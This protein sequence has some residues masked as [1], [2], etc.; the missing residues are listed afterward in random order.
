MSATFRGFTTIWYHHTS[1]TIRIMDEFTYYGSLLATIANSR[2]LFNTKRQ[3]GDYIGFSLE[4]NSITKIRSSFQRKAIFAELAQEFG[5]LGTYEYTLVQLIE[6]YELASTFYV[7]V[8]ERYF[9]TDRDQ[10]LMLLLHYRFG[11]AELPQEQPLREVMASIYNK[12]KDDERVSVVF[13]LLLSLHVLPKF[14]ARG[15][16][17]D[18]LMDDIDTVFDFLRRFVNECGVMPNLPLV[19]INHDIL[20]EAKA[21]DGA[22]LS[23]YC[24]AIL[25]NMTHEILNRNRYCCHPILTQQYINELDATA[26]PLYLDGLWVENE[27]NDTVFWKLQKTGRNSTFATRYMFSHDT[28]SGN[29]VRYYM[30]FYTDNNGCTIS[31]PQLS[32][33]IIK[34]GIPDF[35]WV[36]WYD[37]FV[38]DEEDTQ[39]MEFERLTANPNLPAKLSLHRV[40]SDKTLELYQKILDTYDIKDLYPECHYDFALSS[41]AITRNAIYIEADNGYFRIPFDSNPNFE[42]ASLDDK[43]GMLTMGN[44]TYIAFDERGIYLDV[45]DVDEAKEKYNITLHD[46]I[47][48]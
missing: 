17:I 25:I 41:S 1:T 13:L 42:G 47:S 27:G 39:H 35:T 19:Q 24:R 34:Q 22:Q 48:L 5:N 21:N 18:N 40:N 29:Y 12:E 44:R 4:V 3:L 26:N 2:L 14:T 31:M 10:R 28:Q 36:A 20:R 37:S 16:D 38:D 15:G 43:I 6:Q 9:K 11:K 8:A 46:S 33:H 45:T 30:T 23:L 7:D 32:Y